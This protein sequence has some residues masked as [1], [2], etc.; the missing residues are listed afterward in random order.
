MPVDNILELFKAD[1]ARKAFLVA[2]LA[3]GSV[4]ILGAFLNI[5]RAN[6]LGAALAHTIFS[7]GAL[8]YLLAF[9]VFP[10]ALV[11]A[12]VVSFS[13]YFLAVKEGGAIERTSGLLFTFTMALGILFVSLMKKY[14]PS[15]MALLFGDILTVTSEDIVAS[16]VTALLTLAGF[17]LFSR[18]LVLV[19]QDREYARVLGIKV[20]FLEAAFLSVLSLASVSFIKGI[21]ALLFFAFLFSPPATASVVCRGLSCYFLLSLIVGVLSSLLGTAFSFM[22]D[23]PSGPAIVM[24]LMFFYSVAWLISLVR[25]KV[26]G[27]ER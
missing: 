26:H 16:F 8:A 27:K 9:P 10:V 6:F 14:D 24:V 13:S 1:F 18:K 19:F 23:I 15:V 4:S 22:F 25:L 17:I 7:A 3:G 5:R 11:S 2:F 12:I 20:V 21:G